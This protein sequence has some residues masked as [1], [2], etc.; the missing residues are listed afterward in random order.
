MEILFI[1]LLIVIICL[2]LLFSTTSGTEEKKKIHAQEKGRLGE[3]RVQGI[4]DWNLGADYHDFDDVLL[5]LPNGEST[6]IDH[7]VISIYGVFVVET[8]NKSGWIFAQE[9]ERQ[10]TQTFPNGKKYR[11]QNPLH[12]NY[13]HCQAIADLLAIPREKIHSAVVFIG[14]A[15][16]KTDIPNQVY[17]GKSAYAA[18]YEQKKE[19]LFEEK[20]IP[21]LIARLQH[22]RLENNADNLQ[23]HIEQLHRTPR[24]PKCGAKMLE[25]TAKKGEFAGQHFYG[26]SRFPHYRHTQ[27]ISQ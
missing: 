10:W 24:C 17:C 13:K 21:S 20:E 3:R 7:I 9:R 27:P 16:F 22:A 19:I 26:C 11:F 15:E 2:G 23:Q 14:D 5:K 4:H 6:Q 8:K 12:Q 25:R 1:V 18:L